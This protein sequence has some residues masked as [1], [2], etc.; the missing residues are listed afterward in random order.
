MLN[1][2]ISDTAIEDVKIIEPK[3]FEDDRGWFFEAFNQKIF[4]QNLDSSV[5][6]V[7]DNHSRSEKGV[8]RGLHYQKSPYEQGK[9]VRVISGE[10]FDV[11]VDLRPHSKTFGYWVGEHLSAD[12]K[13]QLWIPAGFAHG[14]Y[15]LTDNTEVLYKTTNFYHKDSEVS[16][17]WND[18]E[19]NITW[20][21]TEQPKLSKKDGE[22]IPFIKFKESL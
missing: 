9:L 5:H 14:F 3:V 18:A 4:N 20:P 10:I 6:F 8:L 7:Q 22:S 16:I 13:K 2:K 19:L 12:N 17:K 21:L 11:A 1:L 15:T